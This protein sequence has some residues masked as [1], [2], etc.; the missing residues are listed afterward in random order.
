MLSVCDVPEIAECTQVSEVEKKWGL[1]KN[2]PL[3]SSKPINLS[4]TTVYTAI[5][6]NSQVNNFATLKKR[7]C[8]SLDQT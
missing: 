5:G 1:P 3:P 8:D 4:N 7:G 2:K 6:F